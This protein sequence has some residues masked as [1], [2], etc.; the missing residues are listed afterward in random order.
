METKSEVFVFMCVLPV[1][2]LRQ[3]REETKK[4]RKMKLSAELARLRKRK[5]HL[6][7]QA[8]V[9]QQQVKINSVMFKLVLGDSLKHVFL[10]SVLAYTPHQY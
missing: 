8:Q 7:S 6:E 4:E 3:F 2:M 5:G 9:H 1:R 10:W